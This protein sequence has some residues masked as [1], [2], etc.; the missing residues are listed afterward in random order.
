[1][2]TPNWNDL[3][4]GTVVVLDSLSKPT[5]LSSKSQGSWV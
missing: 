3:K 5:D 1:M 4:F 2:K